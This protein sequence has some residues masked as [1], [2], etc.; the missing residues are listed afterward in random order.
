VAPSTGRQS[1]IDLEEDIDADAEIA[2]IQGRRLPFAD[3][4]C[5]AIFELVQPAGRAGDDGNSGLKAAENVVESTF[6]A[7]KFDGRIRLSDI[8]SI[9]LSSVFSIETFRTISCPLDRA[10]SS[11][12]WPILP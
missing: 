1:S 8:G 2:G 3:R 7:G 11:I 5:L 10:I 4:A 6:G 9:V 12:A